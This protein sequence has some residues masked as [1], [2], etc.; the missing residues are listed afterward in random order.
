M[1]IIDHIF[2]KYERGFR[3]VFLC[4]H[5]K[6]LT[7]GDRNLYERVCCSNI[8]FC[9]LTG[10]SKVVDFETFYNI[11]LNNLTHYQLIVICLTLS[12]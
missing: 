2:I 4:S 3:I 1:I 6:Q 5:R 9:Y 12:I 7:P 8:L 11:A 10:H